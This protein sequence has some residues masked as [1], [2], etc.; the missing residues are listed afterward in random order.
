MHSKNNIKTI[1]W[2]SYI[3]FVGH[4]QATFFHFFLQGC[5]V[6]LHR[7]IR[8][9]QTTSNAQHQTLAANQ[10]KYIKS[11]IIMKMKTRTFWFL[12]S[13]K[14]RLTFLTA[15]GILGPCTSFSF[16]SIIF[17]FL[18]SLICLASC[19]ISC[20]SSSSLSSLESYSPACSRSSSSFSSSP[21]RWNRCESE[22]D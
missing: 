8:A 9:N 3:I 1:K 11:R 22:H 19:R 20:I 7:A 13:S 12:S 2:I 21:S 5:S 16:D 6:H 15:R 17:S 4:V 14:D 10:D 18:F